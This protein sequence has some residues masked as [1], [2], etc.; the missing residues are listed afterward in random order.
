MHR[1]NVVHLFYFSVQITIS[2]VSLLS[3][4]HVTLYIIITI[5]NCRSVSTMVNHNQNSPTRLSSDIKKANL[6]CTRTDE[7]PA[8]DMDTL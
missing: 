7:T 1:R 4:L 2:L 6:L 3:E 5:L 8:A